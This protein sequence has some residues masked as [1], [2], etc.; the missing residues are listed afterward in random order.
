MM[1]Q[2]GIWPTS[3][4]GTLLKNHLVLTLSMLDS[5]EHSALRAVDSA[6][7]STQA[8]GAQIIYSRCKG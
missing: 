4:L 5:Q 7:D 3:F 8:D 1:E 6:A 2:M